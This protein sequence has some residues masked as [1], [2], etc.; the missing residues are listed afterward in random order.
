MPREARWLCPQLPRWL[1]RGRRW[2]W[3]SSD[4][5][6]RQQHNGW[7]WLPDP[8]KRSRFLDFGKKGGRARA[9]EAPSERGEPRVAR[10]ARSCRCGVVCSV[11]HGPVRRQELGAGR[12][13]HVPAPLPR[14]PIGGDAPCPAT[15]CGRGARPFLCHARADV[16]QGT[17]GQC[18]GCLSDASPAHDHAGAK[19]REAAAA[20]DDAAVQESPDARAD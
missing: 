12:A 5:Y 16:L 20:R 19:L 9:G 1:R 2:L 8:C 6:V 18:L 17:R 10:R 11:L 4:P 15:R 14:R 13:A 7:R 3:C